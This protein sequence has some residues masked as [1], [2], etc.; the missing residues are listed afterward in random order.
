MEAHIPILKIPPYLF[1]YRLS[2]VPLLSLLKL[3]FHQFL[4][5]HPQMDGLINS[6]GRKSIWLF[7][8]YDDLN[9]S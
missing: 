1:K 5:L 9:P 7:V 6:C 2:P 3:C 8:E 4:F